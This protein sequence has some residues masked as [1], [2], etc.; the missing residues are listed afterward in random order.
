MTMYPC[1]VVKERRTREA[2]EL[3]VHQMEATAQKLHKHYSQCFLQLARQV[4]GGTVELMF[5]FVYKLNTSLLHCRLYKLISVKEMHKHVVPYV[6]S[7]VVA[8]T[9]I[10]HVYASVRTS[11][12]YASVRTSMCTHL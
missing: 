7:G 2:L 8:V 1:A 5:G 4:S 11:H 6:K 10:S 3:R 9:E 12:V